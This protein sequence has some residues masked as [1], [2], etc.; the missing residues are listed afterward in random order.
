MNDEL[1]RQHFQ[2]IQRQIAALKAE[3]VAGNWEEITA[4]LEGLQLIYEEMQ[5]SLAV[6]DF[7]EEELL[8]Q[9]QRISTLYQQYYDLFNSAPIGYLVTDA[10]G[11]ILEANQTIAQLLNVPHPYLAGKPLAVYVAQ[12]DRST[13]RTNLN[14]LSP[15]SDIQVWQINLSPRNSEP[16]AAEL[17]VAI[18]RNNSG[19]IESLRIGVYDVSREQ[20]TLTQPVEPQNPEPI[21]TAATMPMP[22]LPQSLD[23]LQVLIVDDEADA[24]EF[25]AAVLSSHGIRVT[26]VATAAAA[27]DALERFRPDVLVSDIRMPDDNGYSLIRK[28]R[29]L[30]AQKGWHIPAAAL[31]AYVVEDREKALAAGFESHLHKLAQPR[32]LV[33]MVARLAG[34]V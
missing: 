5:T 12:G 26:A 22:A 33:E 18:A 15:T 8:Q 1:F 6:A 29:Q 31:T 20:Q 9:H 2:G 27:M 16:F 32:E 21:P 23:G 10:N 19:L 14:R 34:R 13:F 17:T 7:V 4:A 25:I 3:Q 30:E 11:L 28:I 24:R